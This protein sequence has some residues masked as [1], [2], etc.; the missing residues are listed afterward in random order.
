MVDEPRLLPH[1]ESTIYHRIDVKEKKA[2]MGGRQESANEKDFV[3]FEP[4]SWASFIDS[5]DSKDIKMLEIELRKSFQVDIRSTSRR[6]AAF[7]MVMEWAELARETQDWHGEKSR[8][9]KLG[10]SLVRN[11][12]DVISIERGLD[13][14]ALRGELDRI[15]NPDDKYALASKKVE[16]KAFKK[17]NVCFACQR[18]GHYQSQC[19]NRQ[20]FR[21]RGNGSAFGKRMY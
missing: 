13:V 14:E 11:L 7:E 1:A 2:V 15:E 16:V 12:R 5:P 20:I 4:A 3:F 21:G 18:P 19:P 17:P 8:C 10:R 6:Q 9:L